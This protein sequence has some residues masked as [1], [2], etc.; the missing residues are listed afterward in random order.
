MFQKWFRKDKI[1]LL[2]YI[3][4]PVYGLSPNDPQTLGWEIKKFRIE[5]SWTKSSGEGV[6]CAVLGQRQ[7]TGQCIPNISQSYC[8]HCRN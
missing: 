5:K 2:P 4:E 3:S 1:G 7:P 6:V 8:L